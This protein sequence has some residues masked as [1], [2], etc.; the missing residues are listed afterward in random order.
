[1]IFVSYVVSF[2]DRS[3]IFKSVCIDDKIENYDDVKRIEKI[4][5]YKV[6]ILN[7]KTF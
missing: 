3:S 2:V 5:G 7:W 6:T 1:M 4:I